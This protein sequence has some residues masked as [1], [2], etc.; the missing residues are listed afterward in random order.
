VTLVGLL[1]DGAATLLALA[2]VL[3]CSAHVVDDRVEL[4]GHR[5][6]WECAYRARTGRPCASCGLTRGWVAM[7]HGD[8]VGARAANRTAPLT[9]VAA[10]LFV[11]VSVALHAWRIGRTRRDLLRMAAFVLLLASFGRILIDNVALQIGR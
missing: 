1:H 11:L 7:G 3:S 5:L 4:A 6:G 9:F 8:V 10:A 2:L